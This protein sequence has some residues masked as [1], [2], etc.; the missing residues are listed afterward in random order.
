MTMD[1][2]P[3]DVEILDW[4][5]THN[6]TVL[7]QM[8]GGFACL[9]QAPGGRGQWGPQARSKR[10]AVLATISLCRS[11]RGEAP[12]MTELQGRGLD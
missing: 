12:D 10:D 1:P 7:E 5:F 6:A 2:T 3:T 4:I 11:S 9:Y 8:G